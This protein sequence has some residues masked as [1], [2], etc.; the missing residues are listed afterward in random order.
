MTPKTFV[1]AVCSLVVATCVV[2]F[3]YSE[4]LGMLNARM[5]SNSPGPIRWFYDRLSFG[6]PYGGPFW[7]R[8]SRIVAAV[9]GLAFLALLLWA[10]I[11]LP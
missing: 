9:C 7:N 8:I 6:Q 11:F 10:I 4:Q 3:L 1:I 2:Q 5:I